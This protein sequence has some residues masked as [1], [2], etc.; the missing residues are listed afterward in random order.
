MP[1]QKY[2][3]ARR[4]GNRKWD[5]ANLDRLSIAIPR[6]KKDSWKEAAESSGKS[7]N[8]FIMDAVER[9]IEKGESGGE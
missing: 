1:K 8:R 6:G 9:E 4:D 5:A 2:T 3:E 7:L